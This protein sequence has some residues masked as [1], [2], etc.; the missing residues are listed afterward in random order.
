MKENS[1]AVHAQVPV[2]VASYLLNEKRPDIH[3]LEARMKVNIVLV[4]N[5]HLDTPHYKVERLRH[6]DLNQEG[7]LPAS[8]NLVEA[9]AEETAYAMPQEARA[10]RQE[11]LV[12]GVTPEQPAP[13]VPPKP[14]VPIAPIAQAPG[15]SGILDRIIG[16]FRHTE[17]QA[18]PAPVAA[19]A[20]PRSEPPRR[21]RGDRVDRGPRRDRGFDRGQPRGEVQE[22]PRGERPPRSERPPAQARQQGERD[23]GERDRGGDR[24]GERPPRGPRFED[25]RRDERAT[26]D[27]RPHVAPAA[28]GSPPPSSAADEER[29]GGRRNRRDR[30]EGRDRRPPRAE[31]ASPPSTETVV[32]AAP[33]VP[34]AAIPS[35]NELERSEAGAPRPLETEPTGLVTAPSE[36]SKESPRVSQL[37]IDTALRASG[38]VMIETDRDKVSYTATEDEP[39]APRVR[40]E[41]RPPPPDLDQPLMQVETRTSESDTAPPR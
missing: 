11:A 8:Y 19:V 41:R 40:R 10:L 36:V 31:P 20:M 4:P 6:D 32:P 34:M 18:P 3:A 2:D 17:P 37:D 15:P 5:V 38:L 22:R 12:R 29:R 13:V 7:A 27:S 28:A 9:P 25:R 33:M 30:G 1:A 16:W 26:Q 21:E 35:S 23:R 24:R 14:A 39:V